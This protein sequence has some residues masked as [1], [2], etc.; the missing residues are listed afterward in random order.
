M[1][2]VDTFSGV[3]AALTELGALPASRIGRP[4]LDRLR[5]LLEGGVIEKRKRGAGMVYEVLNK[6]KF[7]VFC[8]KEYPSGLYGERIEKGLSGK[9][10]AV[11]AFRDAHRGTTSSHN[12][13]L[14]R[15]FG[16]AQ[17]VSCD[18]ESLPV[19]R[20]TEMASVAAINA[21]GPAC[22]WQ[23]TGRVA[24]VENIEFFYRAEEFTEGLDFVLWN[25]GRAR[26]KTIDW[27]AAQQA[28]LE[29]IHFGDYDPVGL[30]EYLKLKN[31]CPHLQVSLYIPE[32]L[33]ALFA[34]GKGKRLTAQSSY[35]KGL[36]S[37]KDP[38]VR[39]VLS[40]CHEHNKGLDQEALL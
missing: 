30:G 25:A 23:I 35:V 10:F 37:S 21:D 36:L 11:A 6:T 14:I 29:L 16:S 1:T 12:P 15:G 3:L 38:G 27:L 32:N 19:A 13:V 34:Y 17:L 39:L 33:A 2:P 22:K 9:A 28:G 18:G 40:L 7:E 24:L 20:L 4:S 31:A 26:N 5:P 8:E